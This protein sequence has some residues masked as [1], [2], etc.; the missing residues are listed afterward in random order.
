MLELTIR[1]PDRLGQ[2]LQRYRERL[3]EVLDRGLRELEAESPA[4]FEDENAIMA[5]LTS[6][7]APEQVLAIRPTPE[8]QERVSELLAQ[9]KERS[10]TS[11]EEAEL[12]R[13]LLLEHLVRLAKAHAYRQLAGHEV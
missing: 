8:L 2:Q 4:G 11:A 1:V 7:P 13:H 10:L 12:S 5:L 6:R 3:P 9:N